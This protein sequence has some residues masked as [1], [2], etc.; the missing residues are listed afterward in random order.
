MAEVRNRSGTLANTG[1]SSPSRYSNGSNH[2]I[3]SQYLDVPG[4]PAP[5]PEVTTPMSV[6]PF[7]PSESFSFP[8]PPQPP[9]ASDHETDWLASSPTGDSGR[10]LTP[11]QVGA[12]NSNNNAVVANPAD[13]IGGPIS[14]PFSDPSVDAGTS[15]SPEPDTEFAPVEVI[16]RPF[17][18]TLDDEM[19]VMPGNSVRVVK[20]FDDGWAYVEMVGTTAKGL[21]PIDCMREAGEELPAFLA[22]KRVSSYYGEGDGVVGQVIGGAV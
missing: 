16:R 1:S 14:N 6:R 11:N 7:S 22:S 10:I 15:L 20:A 8:K 2:S 17:A 13:N 18:P 12:F 5:P 9:S 19:S 21:I 3:T 4:M